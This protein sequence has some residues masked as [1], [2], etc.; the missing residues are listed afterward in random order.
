M[1]FSARG[2]QEAADIY[3]SCIPGSFISELTRLFTSVPVCRLR[4]SFW[5]LAGA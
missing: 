3:G 4:S 1:G 2:D 5:D